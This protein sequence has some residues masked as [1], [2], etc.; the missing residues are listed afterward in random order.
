MTATP[1]IRVVHLVT[2]L[3]IGGL[4]KVVLD[5]VRRRTQN[6]FGMHVIC[7]DSSGVLE[8]AFAD[9]GVAVDTIGTSGSVPA[10]ILRL[11]LRLRQLKPHVLHTHNPQAHLHGSLAGGLAK[12][13]FVVHT[14]HGREYAD[15]HLIAAMSRLGSRWTSAFV[16]VSEDA[17]AVARTL[18]GVPARKLRVIHNGI[19]VDRF[20]LRG[21]R[22]A[23]AAVRAVTVGRL[24]PVK[25]QLTMLRAVRAVV[26]TNPAFR[27]AIVGDGPSRPEL[28]AERLA[29]GLADH[30]RFLGYRDCVGPF[31]AAADFFVLSSVSEGVSLALLEAMACGLPAVATDVGGNREVVVPGETGYLVPAG[32]PAALADAMHALHADAAALDRMGRAARRR[33]EGAFNLNRV[34]A[35]Y[36][37]MY[38]E[39]LAG[40]APAAARSP[41]PLQASEAPQ[42]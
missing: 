12:V 1:P 3:A 40:Q 6:V 16:A 30:V 24:D 39:G 20:A 25:D 27:L 4:E 35:Q 8:R 18:D 23:G 7:L 34:V 21:S 19:D 41:L 29:L 9:V 36:E 11:A 17:A 28:E 5:L 38:L 15:R 13:P 31:L 10:R 22:P 2:T 33:V 14:K 32:S 37:G 26:D 42:R